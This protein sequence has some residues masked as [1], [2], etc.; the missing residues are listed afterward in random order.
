MITDTYARVTLTTT[1]PSPE[2]VTLL[3][4]NHLQN[5]PSHIWFN[6]HAQTILE[7]KRKL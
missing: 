7:L 2:K 1:T 4:C 5:I 3:F 6:K